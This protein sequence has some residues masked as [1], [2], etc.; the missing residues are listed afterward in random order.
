MSVCRLES[1]LAMNILCISSQLSHPVLHLLQSLASGTAQLVHTPHTH[2]PFHHHHTPTQPLSETDSHSTIYLKD[3]PLPINIDSTDE[4]SRNTGF[5]S[6]PKK[7]TRFQL[8]EMATLTVGQHR[9]Q[10]NTLNVLGM[11]PSFRDPT[12]ECV[13]SGEETEISAEEEMYYTH[14]PQPYSGGEMQVVRNVSTPN[15][16][17]SYPK[18]VNSSMASQQLSGEGSFSPSLYSQTSGL[19][20]GASKSLD[21]M[22]KLHGEERAQSPPNIEENT[23]AMDGK[24]SIRGTVVSSTGCGTPM[25]DKLLSLESPLNEVISS[26]QEQFSTS[27]PPVVTV[28]DKNVSFPHYVRTAETRCTHY[29]RSIAALSDGARIL[30][31][32]ASPSTDYK[33][34]VYSS[35]P[36]TIDDDDDDDEE[37]TGHSPQFERWP[38]EV[39]LAY[40]F[41]MSQ[42]AIFGKTSL[43]QS[44]ALDGVRGVEGYGLKQLAVYSSHSKD[45]IARNG[46][47]EYCNPP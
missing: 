47:S 40:T 19:K 31:S 23:E 30:D 43:I 13:T 24:G 27:K 34:S 42:I 14:V 21:A 28:D 20:L 25:K 41:S 6:A 9:A 39:A 16:A 12:L 18:T 5:S 17:G 15:L 3:S 29:T 44:A 4:T 2:P 26:S 11:Q 32:R 33:H 37:R 36:L 45:D 38:G 1:V 7:G 10:V 22:I 8:P 46:E 35:M